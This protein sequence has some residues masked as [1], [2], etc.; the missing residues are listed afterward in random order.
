V[1]HRAD[2]II[3]KAVAIASQAAE[4]NRDEAGRIRR[5]VADIEARQSRLVE[6]LL[7][8]GVSEVTK[9]SVNRQM[10]E[11]EVDRQR[12]QAAITNL[13][14]QANDNTET[15]AETI[16]ALLDAA[17][18]NLAAVTKPEAYNRF[19]EQVV[20]P[21]ELVNGKPAQKKLPQAEAEG[22]FTKSS[23]SHGL[24]RS[25]AGGRSAPLQLTDSGEFVGISAPDAS[26][27]AIAAF[28]SL[29]AAA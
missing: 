2:E 6:L 27:S 24:Q 20:G 11:C 28:W 21:I 3:R 10:A 22:S 19:A 9:Q 29:S 14:D 5:D 13:H 26:A 8:R 18:E 16:R 4:S 7:D 1:L 25:I 23:P 15:L 12:L 17:K